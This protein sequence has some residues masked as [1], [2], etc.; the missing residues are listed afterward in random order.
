MSVLG[1]KGKGGNFDPEDGHYADLPP[2]ETREAFPLVAPDMGGSSRQRQISAETFSEPYSP[3]AISSSYH[4]SPPAPS[5]FGPGPTG[6]PF[7]S[8]RLAAVPPQASPSL[9]QVPQSIPTVAIIGSTPRGSVNS[10][11]SEQQPSQDD[12]FDVLAYQRQSMA[13]P[14]QQ[15]ETAF[16]LQS[17]SPLDAWRRGQAQAQVI[18]QSPANQPHQSSPNQH[19]HYESSPGF[20]L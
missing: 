20:A 14:Q 2:P 3:P 17:Q 18:Q 15:E 1:L 6:S 16:D 11:Y 10:R 19:H 9:H 12:G 4:Q 13:G 7:A 8:P 5:P